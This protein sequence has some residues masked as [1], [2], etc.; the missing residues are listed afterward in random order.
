MLR[1]AAFGLLALIAATAPARAEPIVLKLSQFLGP[2]SFFA[3]DFAQ[4][5][6]SELEAAT[7]GKVK[8]ELFD[9]SSPFGS[10]TAQAAQVKAGTI[11]IAL[12]LRG[13]EPERFPRSA[14]IELPFM[15]TDS[16]SGSMALW[17][18]TKAGLFGPEYQDFKLLALHVHNPG[19]IHTA[20]KPVR[21]VADLAGLRFRAPNKAVAATL[22]SVGAS[23]AILQVNEVMDAVKGGRID[24]I[25]TNWGNPLVGFNDLM[26]YHTD[27]AFYTSVFFVVMNKERFESLPPDV[28]AAIDRLSNEALV[29]RFGQLWT[30]WDK[31]VRDGAMAPGHEIIVPTAAEQAKWKAALQPVTSRYLD[32]LAASG[33]TDAREAHARLLR[34]LQP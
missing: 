33:F 2:N 3:V 29:A 7:G 8:V 18:A 6:A 23:P 25:V 19:L 9:G 10:V 15:I 34:A 16:A 5:W 27:V 28:Q 21:D 31:P 20:S 4:P 12:G 17:Q 30:K 14:I 24:G 11:D 1:H 22:S 13:A 26:H 32:D